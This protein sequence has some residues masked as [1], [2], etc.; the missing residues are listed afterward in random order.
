[1]N[2]NKKCR[3]TSVLIG[4]AIITYTGN[5]AEL[6]EVTSSGD[7]VDVLSNNNFRDEDFWMEHVLKD[8]YELNQVYEDIKNNTVCGSKTYRLWISQRWLLNLP[9]ETSNISYDKKMKWLKDAVSQM[10]K[11]YG[12]K[13]AIRFGYSHVPIET[14]N[15][16]L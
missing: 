6:L 1:M 9:D 2:S 3:L 10:L 16:S 8:N 5:M 11:K 13:S 15:I 14:V 7:I 12:Q 4:K